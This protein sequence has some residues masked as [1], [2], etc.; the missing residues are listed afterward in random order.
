MFLLDT[1]IFSE[2]RRVRPHG[3]VVAWLASV[4]AD[5]IFLSAV[6]A[7]EVQNGIETTRAH[8]ALKA[9]QIEAWL[10]SSVLNFSWLPMDVATFRL[11]AKQMARLSDKYL[12]D[13]MIA[14]TAL[15]R[16]L[17]VATRNIKDFRHFNVQTL[18]PFRHPR[19]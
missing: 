16:G 17:T 9:S 4:P 2:L 18:D 11:H 7:A 1:N 15:T 5:H 6:T 19:S 13:S 12:N 8:D 10:D 3:A 14:A